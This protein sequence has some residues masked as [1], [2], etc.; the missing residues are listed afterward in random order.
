MKKIIALAL[1][2][3]MA[4]SMVACGGSSSSKGDSDK[5][6]TNPETIRLLAQSSS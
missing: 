6:A 1:A 3:V 2:M 4:F 5:I